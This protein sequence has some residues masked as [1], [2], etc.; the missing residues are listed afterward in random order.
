[1]FAVRSKVQRAETARLLVLLAIL[2][3]AC[4]GGGSNST[5][6]SSPTPV[7]TTV[8]VALSAASIQVGQSEAASASGLD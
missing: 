3:G 5:G 7:L 2:F 8:S 6:P 4:S 1:M